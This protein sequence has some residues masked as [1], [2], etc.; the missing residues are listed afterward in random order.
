MDKLYNTLA[1]SN[2]KSTAKIN[3]LQA[4]LAT[5]EDQLQDTSKLL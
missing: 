4:K 1:D 3:E 2:S 5:Q